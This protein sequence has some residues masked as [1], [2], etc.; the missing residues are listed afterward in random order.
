MR[1]AVFNDMVNRATGYVVLFEQRDAGMLRSDQLPERD[2]RP[3]DDI[4]HAISAAKTLALLDPSKYVNVYVA[5]AL[6]W[7]PIQ[8]GEKYNP[9]PRPRDYDASGC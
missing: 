7:A 5:R 4:N 8:N 6:D 3:F 2:E 9:Y 1:H